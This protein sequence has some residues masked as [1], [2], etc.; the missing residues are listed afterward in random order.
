MANAHT[1]LD[2]A[3]HCLAFVG[4]E[5]EAGVPP[6]QAG[7]AAH[8]ALLLIAGFR[9]D[10]RG[11]RNLMPHKAHD[12][13]GKLVG[14]QDIIRRAGQNRARGH[15]AKCRRC[16]FLHTDDAASLL[17]EAGSVGA[18]ITCA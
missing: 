15:T 11:R 10:H 2:A 18:I 1:A 3:V 12:L 5:V 4:T 13:A 7:E 8:G 17:H 16:R 9:D 14:R 6:E